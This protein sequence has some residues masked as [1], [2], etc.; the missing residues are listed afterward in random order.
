MKKCN[1]RSYFKEVLI[2]GT[3]CYKNGYPVKNAIVFLEAFFPYKSHG[4]PVKYYKK[5]CGYTATNYNGEFYCLIYDTR[6]YYK[7]KVFNNKCNKLNN[8]SCNIR[9]Y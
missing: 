9:L 2:S 8:V 7:I 4:F 3:V 1:C 5:L 6:Y